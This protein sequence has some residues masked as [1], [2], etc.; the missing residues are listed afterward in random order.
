MRSSVKRIFSLSRASKTVSHQ[1][2]LQH[3]ASLLYQLQD[4]SRSYA[5][6]D[7]NL[8]VL[9]DS[10]H[11]IEGNFALIACNF[12]IIR[13]SDINSIFTFSVAIGAR[14]RQEI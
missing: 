6:P 3:T 14:G 11:A 9:T 1:F 7:H 4:D 12:N 8:C 5:E 2:L 10:Y 13:E